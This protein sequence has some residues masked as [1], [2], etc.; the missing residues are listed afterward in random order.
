M[1]KRN[2]SFILSTTVAGLA[3]LALA[4][5]DRGANNT[6]T[7]TAPGSGTGST[8]GTQIDD[9][10][11]TASV[12]S[13]LMANDNVRSL[14]IDVETNNGVVQ[15]SG[16]VTSQTQ[17]DQALQVARGVSGVREVENRLTVKPAGATAG[18]TTGTVDGSATLGQAADDTAIT[19]R[20]KS[21][22]LAES[23]VSGLAI[24][25][26]TTNGVVRL[27]G[28]VDSQAQIDKANRVASA[29]EGVKSVQN[30]LKVKS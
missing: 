18:S 4:G 13:A 24:N 25:V 8:V 3:A 17:I 28:T 2:T 22:L 6:S 11:L 29:A 10:A 20:V 1:K 23:D 7:G 26:E 21:A 14:D 19:A 15:L 5:C 30:Q 27:T 12:K 9:S 16:D